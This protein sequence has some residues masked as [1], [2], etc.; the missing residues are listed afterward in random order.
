MHCLVI[1]ILFSRNPSTH[2]A[3]YTLTIRRD[4]RVPENS[5]HL[6]LTEESPIN[7]SPLPLSHQPFI[8]TTL[9]APFM[10]SPTLSIDTML[11]HALTLEIG[12][13]QTHSPGVQRFRE[14]VGGRVDK[15]LP[16]LFDRHMQHLPESPGLCTRAQSIFCE[17]CRAP[18]RSSLVTM[19]LAT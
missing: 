8:V 1:L 5:W 15:L 6:L 16:S 18:K 3:S 14:Q 4:S 11:C 2:S 17:R 19:S 9:N 12:R 10:E 13:Q 7:T